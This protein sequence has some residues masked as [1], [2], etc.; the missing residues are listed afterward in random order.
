VHFGTIRVGTMFIRSYIFYDYVAT[1]YGSKVRRFAKSQT[2]Y[3][4]DCYIFSPRITPNARRPEK[5]YLNNTPTRPFIFRIKSERPI[6]LRARNSIK[7]NDERRLKIP[8]NLLEK[9]YRRRL[10]SYRKIT[11]TIV[12]ANVAFTKVPI[13]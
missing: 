12:R 11:Q 13:S 5:S 9:I 10:P 7:F 2:D 6:T 8:I 1:E 3:V 4:N